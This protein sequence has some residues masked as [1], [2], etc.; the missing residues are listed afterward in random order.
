MNKRQA[1]DEAKEPFVFAGG[2]DGIPTPG[3]CTLMLGGGI[4]LIVLALGQGSSG[5]RVGE[6]GSFAQGLLF[7]GAAIGGVGG[8]LLHT[9]L[10]LLDLGTAEETSDL[11]GIEAE[12]LPAVAAQ[13]GVKPRYLINGRPMYALYDFDSATP[14]ESRLLLRA[15]S[16]IAAEP[17]TLLRAA[18]STTPVPANQLLRADTTT[19]RLFAH[20]IPIVDAEASSQFIFL[21][22]PVNPKNPV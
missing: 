7:F 19:T 10:R 16:T 14:H 18:N 4:L 22:N 8:W 9:R 6:N 12:D 5:W 20:Y 1:W 21:G 2:G 17:H 15:S 11:L 3:F 13:Q